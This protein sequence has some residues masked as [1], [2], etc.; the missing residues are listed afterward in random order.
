[1]ILRGRWCDVIV[2]YVHIQRVDK[3]YHAEDSFHEEPKHTLNVHVPSVS[4]ETFSVRYERLRDI[5]IRIVGFGISKN[6]V[7]RSTMF[8]YRN[9]HK[10]I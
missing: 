6:L 8:P 9:V 5:E 1:M 3:T 2:V 7:D 10:F 4:R